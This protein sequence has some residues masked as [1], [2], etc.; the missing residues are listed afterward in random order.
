[1]SE[2][3]ILLDSV[4]EVMKNPEANKSETEELAI[5]PSKR[6]LRRRK[7]K[8][9]KKV[10][11][12]GKDRENVNGKY[13][14]T[15]KGCYSNVATSNCQLR[16]KVKVDVTDSNLILDQTDICFNSHLKVLDSKPVSSLN[17]CFV[18]LARMDKI[19]SSIIRQIA[20]ENSRL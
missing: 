12:G 11:G 8:S 2:K 9:S 7:N 3:Q 14:A 17:S 10:M 15:E 16:L 20:L 19:P 4:S 13:F 5:Q 1:M 18:R 6:K